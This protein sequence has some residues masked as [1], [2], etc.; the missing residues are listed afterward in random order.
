MASV[1][2]PRPSL[3]CG[4]PFVGC[5]RYGSRISRYPYLYLLLRVMMM[6]RHAVQGSECRRR[7]SR[8]HLR[9]AAGAAAHCQARAATHWRPHV[10]EAMQRDG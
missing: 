5:R 8:H 9:R 3:N 1:S 10:E 2:A 4:M 7:G 6:G